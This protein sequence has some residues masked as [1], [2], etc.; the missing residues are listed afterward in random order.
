MSTGKVQELKSGFGAEVTN[1]HFENGVQD[2]DFRL[3]QDAVTKYGVVVIRGTNLSD[4]THLELSRKFGELDD[5]TP[6]NL[7]GRK[8]R[9][10]Y[11]ELF[12]VSNVDVGGGIVDPN[13]PRGHADKG[14]LLFHVDSS[15]N[16]RRA[17]Y[18]L[19][20]VHELP[21]N[22]TGGG[23]AFVD[24]RTAFDELDESTKQNLIDNDYIAAHSLVH[25]KKLAS[26]EFFAD[27]DPN[28]YPFGR[29]KLVQRHE[30]S[31]RLNLYIASHI[32]HLEGL[33]ADSSQQLFDKLYDHARQEKYIVQIDWENP[34]DLIIWDNTC[35]MHRAVAGPFL[36]KHRR[37]M[38]RA[39]VHDS[40]SQ[41][42]G[43]NEHSNVRQG[44]P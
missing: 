21:P 43:L 11:N 2:A 4:E 5:V 17:G 14:N 32:H 3:V 34:G 18:S 25:S 44:L 8:H 30:A 36:Y 37:D 38:R 24:T 15:F 40:S 35:T 42:W 20:L 33:E 16:P 26:P 27:L 9:L 13:S 1:L 41:A 39:T 6:Y 19:L 28:N 12:D 7:A 22:G 23:L 29:H 31:G 10:K